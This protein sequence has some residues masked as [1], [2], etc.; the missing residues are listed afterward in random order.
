MPRTAVSSVTLRRSRAEHP[1]QAQPGLFAQQAVERGGL[2]HI[3][4]SI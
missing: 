1:E 2:I 3:Y 4:K